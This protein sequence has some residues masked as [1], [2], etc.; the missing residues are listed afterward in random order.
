MISIEKIKKEFDYINDSESG[1]FY[2]GHW[3]ILNQP[4]DIE[5]Y[6]MSKDGSLSIDQL[7][8]FEIFI[9][10]IEKIKI[11]AEAYISQDLRTQ[12]HKDSTK[13]NNGTFTF[14]I[15]SIFETG[16]EYDTE[17]ICSK[18]YKK[19]L[20]NKNIDYVIA[21]SKGEILEIIGVN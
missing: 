4:Q 20:F 17:I 19:F 13:I 16:N 7:E 6:F 3:S 11:E 1:S 21:F 18:N 10:N 14:N 8:T 5:L 2:G 12:N 15:V 9:D